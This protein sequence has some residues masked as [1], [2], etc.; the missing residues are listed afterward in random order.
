MFDNVRK[1]LANALRGEVLPQDLSMD[2]RRLL[3]PAA[4]DLEVRHVT[5]CRVV[6]NRVELLDFMP[7]GGVCAEV[8]IFKCQFSKRILERTAP[9]K[10]HLIDMDAQWIEGAKRIFPNEIQSGRVVLHR[11]DSA[12]TM[13]SMPKSYFDWVYIDGDHSYDGC[14][15]DLESAALCLKP[16]GLLALND[17]TFW[18]VSDFCKYGVMEAVNEF[19]LSRDFEFIYLALQG[20]GY[21][22]VVLRKMM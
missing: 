1:K 6:P 22:D 5:N 18:G 16:E 2:G 13:F 20:R 12:T 19:C 17:Y 21:Y 3:W 7:K 14:K 9:H 4:R 10:L 11:G 8:G 15:R